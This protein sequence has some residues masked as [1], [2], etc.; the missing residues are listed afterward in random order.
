MLLEQRKG[1]NIMTKDL[2]AYYG[3]IYKCTNLI[4]G[5]IYIGQTIK[6]LEHRKGLHEITADKNRGFYFHNAIR[7][8]GKENFKWEIIDSGLSKID[9]DNKEIFYI[10]IFNVLNHDF[11]YNIKSGGSCGNPYAG[12]TKEEMNVISKRKSQ[13]FK[14]RIFTQEHKLKISQ[15]RI[16]FSKDKWAEI[17]LKEKLTKLKRTEEQKEITKLKYKNTRENKSEEERRET[18]R[19]LSESKKGEKNPFYGKKRPEHSEFMK[20]QFHH[21][22]G[23]ESAQFGKKHSEE[24]KRKIGDK[25]RGKIVSKESIEKQKISSKKTRDCRTDAEKQIISQKISRAMKG[26]KNPRA[27]KIMCIE[28]GYIFGCLKDVNIKGLTKKAINEN[29]S[30]GGFTYKII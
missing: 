22:K 18:R 4:N 8:Y 20:T 5:K 25:H 11:G 17:R 29:K 28:T 3:I 24:T 1:K 19:K 12:K 15:T 2:V 6:G 26:S 21:K 13:A 30:F 23:E 14:G 9:L 27:I 7:K 10:N 16:N